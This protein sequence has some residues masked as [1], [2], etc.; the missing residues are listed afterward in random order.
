MK[1]STV[2]A[3]ILA[4]LA[5]TACGDVPVDSAPTGSMRMALVASGPDGVSY[6]LRN[7]LFDISGPTALSLD[8]ESDPDASVLATSVPA[9]SYQ[10]GLEDGWYVE[11]IDSGRVLTV[12]AVLMSANPQA[13]TLTSGGT[14]DVVFVFQVNNLP[15]RFSPGTLDVAIEVVECDGSPGQWNGCRGNGCAV[16]TELLAQYPRYIQNHPRCSPNPTC[17]GQFYTC[18]DRCPQPTDLDR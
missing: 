1:K 18:N 7:A 13:A 16:C 12:N 11:Q 3:W 17:A 4:G 5:F 10:I 2:F 6:R 8:S 9:G 15:V 14:S